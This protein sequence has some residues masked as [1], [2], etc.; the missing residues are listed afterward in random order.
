MFHY[1]WVWTKMHWHFIC[2]MDP[3]SFIY[4][5]PSINYFIIH[6]FGFGVSLPRSYIYPV[7]AIYN[8]LS[9][10]FISYIA[11]GLLY[12]LL[13]WVKTLTLSSL[14]AG[15]TSSSSSC[16]RISL[17]AA[18]SIMTITNAL[19]HFSHYIQATARAQILSKW[20]IRTKLSFTQQRKL[21]KLCI[22]YQPGNDSL[23]FI[24][25]A[26]LWGKRFKSFRS[27]YGGPHFVIFVLKVQL[28]LSKCF[29]RRH[30]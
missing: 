18:A 1:P 16:W 30:S 28:F 7:H 11:L 23:Q 27:W 9:R 22:F 2:H 12:L 5:G 14:T 19:S 6:L 10:F 20:K 3:A 8:H 4:S 21:R 29:Y 13:S 26:A 17:A 24:D 15:T 25:G